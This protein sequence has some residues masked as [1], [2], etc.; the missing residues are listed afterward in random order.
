[1][2]FRDFV[3]PILRTP[4]TQSDKCVKTLVSDY[5]LTTNMINV[6]KHC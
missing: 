1:M 5:S 4:K 2:T 6:P 3:F